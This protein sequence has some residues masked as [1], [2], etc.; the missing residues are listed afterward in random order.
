[1]VNGSESGSN[2]FTHTVYDSHT[3][4]KDNDGEVIQGYFD[5]ICEC[6][7]AQQAEDIAQALN[8]KGW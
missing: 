2:V 6:F 3:P 1:V 8:E 5:T 4:L 7:D